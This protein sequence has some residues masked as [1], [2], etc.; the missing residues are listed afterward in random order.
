MLTKLWILYMPY[1]MTKTILLII[2]LTI[3]SGC[4]S[5]RTNKPV[6]P[7]LIYSE[8]YDGKHIEYYK[9]KNGTKFMRF[10]LSNGAVREMDMFK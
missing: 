9:R 2:S 8:T 1:F 5:T 7:V 6:Y 10:K 4:A 3:L